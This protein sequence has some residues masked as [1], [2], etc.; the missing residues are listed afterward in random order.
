MRYEERRIIEAFEARGAN[1]SRIDPRRFHMEIGDAPNWSGRV[2]LNREIA[3]GR[4]LQFAALVESTGAIVINDSLS[5]SRSADKGKA[6]EVLAHA[7][8]AVPRT[9]VALG[10][11]MALEAIDHLGYPVVSKPVFGSWGRLVTLIRDAD[12]ADCLVQFTEELSPHRRTCCKSIS[13]R[14][15]EMSVS[16]WSGT[17]SWGPPLTRRALGDQTLEPVGLGRRRTSRQIWSAC[18]SRRR[19]PSAWRLRA[20]T[21]S[22]PPMGDCLFSRLIILL[23][24]RNSNV[25][26]EGVRA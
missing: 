3:Q 8:V 4:A 23:G 22:K 5:S 26:T 9:I 7:G 25:L 11:E 20:W 13:A 6:T 24:L 16:L 1:S 15:D 17:A 18:H 2:V 19:G 21:S 12:A 14:N 10:P